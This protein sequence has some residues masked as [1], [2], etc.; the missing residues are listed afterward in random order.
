MPDHADKVFLNGLIFPGYRGTKP[1][2][3][4]LAQWF[5]VNIKVLATFIPQRRL[6]TLPAPFITCAPTAQYMRCWR[7]NFR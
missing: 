7:M 4:S 2:E 3:R 5:Q 1:E 6:V